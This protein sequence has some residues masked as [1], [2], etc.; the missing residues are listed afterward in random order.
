MHIIYIYIYNIHNKDR[1]ETFYKYHVYFFLNNMYMCHGNDKNT[2]K[3]KSLSDKFLNA[4]IQKQPRN[5]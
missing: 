1:V 2:H 3:K 5:I 4:F